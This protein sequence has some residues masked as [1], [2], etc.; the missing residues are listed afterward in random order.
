MAT[1]RA[2]D[3]IVGDVI[4][5]DTGYNAH[6]FM[7]WVTVQK[8]SLTRGLF[9]QLNVSLVIAYSNLVGHNHAQFA[10]GDK[11]TVKD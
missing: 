11:L 7:E 8:V 6:E 3:L 9:K 1:K 5:I 10:P 2:I 4:Y